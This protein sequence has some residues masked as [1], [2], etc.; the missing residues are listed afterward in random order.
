MRV[1]EIMEDFQR[2]QTYIA[3]IRANPSA[4][5]YN[6]EGFVVLRRCV[7][8]AQVLLAQHPF[9]VQNGTGLDEDQNKVQLRR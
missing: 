2:L 9:Q 1:R 3:S 4:E 8:D 5:E 7:A 6:E